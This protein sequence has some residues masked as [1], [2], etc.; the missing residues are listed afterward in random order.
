MRSQHDV[1][2][3]TCCCRLSIWWRKMPS[4]ADHSA[5]HASTSA[6]TPPCAAATTPIC[7][8]CKQRA[9]QACL[10]PC[11]LTCHNSVYAIVVNLQSSHVLYRRKL[12]SAQ[13]YHALSPQQDPFTF[14]VA[15]AHE[16]CDATVG[17]GAGTSGARSTPAHSSRRP[18][19]G[20]PPAARPV[21]TR[22]LDASLPAQVRHLLLPAGQRLTCRIHTF[23]A[24]VLPLSG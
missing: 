10:P 6:S 9:D 14:L 7:C 24:H 16:A 1:S 22:W 17:A 8:A 15:A 19:A 18:A 21:G 4:L 13:V 3:V 11:S 2:V 20:F 12:A 23:W 5:W